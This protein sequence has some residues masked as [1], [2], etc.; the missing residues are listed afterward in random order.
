MTTATREYVFDARKAEWDQQYI[1]DAQGNQIKGSNNLDLADGN[2][3]RPQGFIGIM[4]NGLRA[5]PHYHNEAQFQVGL[6]GALDSPG[7]HMEARAVHYTDPNT[8]YGPL[9]FRGCKV[10]VLRPRKTS[11]SMYM[12]DRENRALRNPYGREL[13]GAAKDVP[14]ETVTYGATRRKVLFAGNGPAAV[15]LEYAPHTEAHPVR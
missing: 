9:E 8:S 4:Y 11:R 12:R 6:E 3:G 13:V 2:D 14:W 15:L 1:K 7:H 10:A 5:E